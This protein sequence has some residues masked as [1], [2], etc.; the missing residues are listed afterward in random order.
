ML[1]ILDEAGGY[2][3]GLVLA[4]VSG[5]AALTFGDTGVFTAAGTAKLI[6]AAAFYHLVE[7]G[8]AGLDDPMGDYDAATPTTMTSSG[9]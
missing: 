3:I 2:R 4:D 1:S 8:E 5:D 9:S 6:T 7:L